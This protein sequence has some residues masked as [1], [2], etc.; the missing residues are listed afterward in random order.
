VGDALTAAEAIKLLE[1]VDNELEGGGEVE[2]SQPK[3]CALSKCSI[4]KSE[5]HTAQTCAQQ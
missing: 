4:C 1:I 2:S 5:E 3:K